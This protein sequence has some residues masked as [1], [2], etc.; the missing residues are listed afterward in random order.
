MRYL[1]DTNIVIYYFNGITNDES[2]HGLLAASFNISII[3]KIEFLGWSPFATD[4]LL[5]D[6]ARG[7]IGHANIIG[8]DDAIAEKTIEIRQRHRIKTPDA[9]IAATAMVHGLTIATN[10]VADFNPL[11]VETLSIGVLSGDNI[12]R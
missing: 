6:K 10:N 11:G 5:Y 7:F 12:P 1:I 3:T 4:R 9:L 2:I 8:L